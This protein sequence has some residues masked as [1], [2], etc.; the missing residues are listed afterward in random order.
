MRWRRE[1]LITFARLKRQ[2]LKA[3]CDGGHALVGFNRHSAAITVWKVKI[4]SDIN[5][6]G[7]SP[8]D[9]VT[10]SVTKAVAIGVRKA[11]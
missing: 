2:I 5:R 10:V 8:D 1:P 7:A 9:D 3:T 6:A 11:N 4:S